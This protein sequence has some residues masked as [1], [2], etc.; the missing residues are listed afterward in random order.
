MIVPETVGLWWQQRKRW[1]LGLGQVLRRHSSV[2]TD[3]RWRRMFPL[4]LESA[5]SYMWALTFVSVTAF[6][7][8]C[9]AVGHPPKG[10]SPIPNF[11]GMLLYSCCLLQL[12]CGTWLDSKYDPGIV[13]H[14]PVSIIY[15][16]FYWILLA[17]ASCI[18]TTRGLLQRT[19]FTKPT[20]WHIQH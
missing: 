15:P 9:Y 19:D 13:R 10:G 17:M 16:T 11:W 1:A 20:R 14:Y 5:M 3:W 2:F 8:F 18:Y 4:Y 6:W 12:A 7:I